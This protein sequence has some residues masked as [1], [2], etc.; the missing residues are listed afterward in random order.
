MATWDAQGIEIKSTNWTQWHTPGIPAWV[1]S[2]A[3]TWNPSLGNWRQEDEKFVIKVKTGASEIRCEGGEEEP[4]QE[5]CT[6]SAL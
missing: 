5:S 4:E 6:P 2:L 1:S 3:H